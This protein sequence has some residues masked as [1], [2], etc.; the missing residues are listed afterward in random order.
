MK[1]Q[2]IYRRTSFGSP[3]MSALPNYSEVGN[4]HCMLVMKNTVR[5]KE[6]LLRGEVIAVL[7]AITVRLDDTCLEDHSLIPVRASLCFSNSPKPTLPGNGVLLHERT[8]RQDLAGTYGP[9]GSRYSQI[10]LP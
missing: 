9:G 1:I 6:D 10:S 5:P 2:S 7:S 4:P 8:E 3:E